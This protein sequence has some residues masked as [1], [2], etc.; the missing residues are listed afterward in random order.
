MANGSNQAYGLDG[1]FSFFQD[2]NF[3]GYLAKTTTP[4]LHGRDLSHQVRF[5][6]PGDRYG[7]TVEQ[8]QIG[9]NFNPEIGFLRRENFRRDFAEVR[10][11][12]RPTSLAMIR[13]FTFEA[14]LDYTVTADTGKLETRQRVGSFEIE[15][16]NSDRVEFDVVDVHERI[17]EPFGVSGGTVAAGE[18]DFRHVEVVYTFGRQRPASGSVFLR[19]GSFYAGDITVLEVNSARLSLVPGLVIEPSV[20]LNWIDVPAGSFATKLV[21]TRASYSFTPRVF[22]SV[23]LQYNMSTDALNAALRL[24]WEYGRGAN[25]L[26]CSRKTATSRRRIFEMCE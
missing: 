16:E 15:F 21:R 20:S 26:S 17:D 10:F 12:P 7:A 1:N 13:Q 22:F 25:S 3:S 4:G 9:T 23:L 19:R 24:R 14:N 6:Y 8:L 2:L 11:T 5:D 18:Y